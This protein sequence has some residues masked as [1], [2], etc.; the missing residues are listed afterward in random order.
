MRGDGVVAGEGRV[1]DD[2]N[3][4]ISTQI[5]CP[6]LLLAC[7]LITSWGVIGCA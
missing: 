4:R 3:Y 1:V 7:V 2:Q 6:T 5:G